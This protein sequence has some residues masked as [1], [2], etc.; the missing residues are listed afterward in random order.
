MH[1]DPE[2]SPKKRLEIVHK[3]VRLAKQSTNRHKDL[4]TSQT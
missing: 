3:A 4:G 1:A 2:Q